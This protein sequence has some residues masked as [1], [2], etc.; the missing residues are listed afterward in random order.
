V[1]KSWLSYAN[2]S[3]DYERKARFLPALLSVLPLLPASAALGGPLSEWLKLVL[4]GVGIGAVIAVGLSHASS[5]MG[6]RLQQKLWPRWPHDSPTN[7]WLNPE[8]ERTSRQQREL[9]YGAAK[10]L[11]GID[12]AEAVASG[13]GVEATINDAVSALR[14]VFW[15]R[16]EA[17]RLRTHNVDYGFARNLTGMR[18]IWLGFLSASTIACWVTYIWIDTDSLLWAVIS[19]LLMVIL[20]PIAS[21]VMP[22]YVRTKATYYA[23][24]FF[25]TLRAVDQ[26]AGNPEVVFA[27]PEPRTS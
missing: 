27:K 5:A 10:R 18:P 3:D 17:G 8:E 4:G 22:A 26:A 19:T 7:R 16:P 2:L 23:E 1:A 15:E 21:W 6:N 24:S 12:I 11:V 25:G 20:V 13:E 9:W 14:N